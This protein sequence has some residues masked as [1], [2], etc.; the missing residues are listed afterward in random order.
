MKY[1][2]LLIGMSV[3]VPFTVQAGTMEYR[4]WDS[5]PHDVVMAP[6]RASFSMH[7]R[8]AAR[9]LMDGQDVSR[10]SRHDLD[11][12]DEQFLDSTFIAAH[13]T[14]RH[15]ASDV[16]RVYYAMSGNSEPWPIESEASRSH[17]VAEGLFVEDPTVVSTRRPFSEYM[18][19]PSG[20]VWAHAEP[21]DKSAIEAGAVNADDPSTIYTGSAEFKVMRD[22]EKDIQAGLV[23][24]RGNVAVFVSRKP[25]Q[26]CDVAL[27]NFA[28]RYAGDM[29][30]N[31]IDDP[32]S[33]I[34]QR[35]LRDRQAFMMT[36]RAS[37]PARWDLYPVRPS[38]P[39]FG[40]C[41]ASIR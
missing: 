9:W 11:L 30:V 7:A 17:Y 1:A 28:L 15:G 34:S 27:R 18:R 2:I 33:W 29:W 25:C 12:F 6:L 21:G 19:V 35:F 24:S 3:V 16:T 5:D 22:I 31:M 20:A 14:Y 36:V 39:V 4:R 32:G 40:Q 26:A 10:L 13:Y 38:S 23:P 8:A 37:L 41:T